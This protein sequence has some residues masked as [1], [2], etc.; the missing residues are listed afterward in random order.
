MS[1][2]IVLH[3]VIPSPVSF[4]A[5][6]IICSAYFL[7]VCIKNKHSEDIII[8]IE[9]VVVMYKMLCTKPTRIVP[10]NDEVYE[11]LTTIIA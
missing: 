7:Q 3:I 4:S 8:L 11:N 9:T 10:N 6:F 2:I 5:S 1:F